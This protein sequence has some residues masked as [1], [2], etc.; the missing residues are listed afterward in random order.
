MLEKLIANVP[1]QTTVAVTLNGTPIKGSPYQVTV[2]K[3]TCVDT[4]ADSRWT[5]VVED[6]IDKANIIEPSE[7]TLQVR[8][9]K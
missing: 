7:F 9:K 2:D 8:H 1:G 5:G 3:N 4:E 6:G